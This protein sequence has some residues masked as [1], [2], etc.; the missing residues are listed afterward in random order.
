MG[1][2]RSCTGQFLH[3]LPWLKLLALTGAIRMM[4]NQ[5]VKGYRTNKGPYLHFL[6]AMA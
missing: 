6:E 4:D 2:N 5:C 3:H 1:K